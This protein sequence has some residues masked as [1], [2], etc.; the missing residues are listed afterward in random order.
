M[1]LILIWL[2]TCSS[3]TQRIRKNVTVSMPSCVRCTEGRAK[4]DSTITVPIE[5]HVMLQCTPNRATNGGINP[6]MATTLATGM[7]MNAHPT[8]TTDHPSTCFAMSTKST[9]NPMNRYP[10]LNAV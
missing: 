6:Y 5:L 9:M 7:A 8:R 3:T 4:T 10:V 2:G 1:I